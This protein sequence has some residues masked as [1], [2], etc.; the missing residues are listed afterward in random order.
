MKKLILL[1]GVLLLVGAGVYFFAL[2]GNE[3]PG[4]ETGTEELA[5]APEDAEIPEEDIETEYEQVVNEFYINFYK[6]GPP[7]GDPAAAEAALAMLSTDAQAV[8]SQA[9]ST[10]A[11]L[12]QFVGVQD[13]PDVGMDVVMIVETETGAD[14]QTLWKYSGGENQKVFTL[15]REEGALKIDQV[16]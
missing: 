1:V 8:V 2:R 3:A 11:G 16:N 12:A 7:E 15:V 9:G 13:L 6:S 5:S 14:V 10:T 4:N